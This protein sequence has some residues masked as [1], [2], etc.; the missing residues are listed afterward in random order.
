L[1]KVKSG[2]LRP[3]AVR[4]YA[5]WELTLGFEKS[6]KQLNGAAYD[7]ATGRIFVSQGN[8]EQPIIHVFKVTVP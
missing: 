6:V 4:P 1:A 3:W 7:P 2:Q 8:G 5:T